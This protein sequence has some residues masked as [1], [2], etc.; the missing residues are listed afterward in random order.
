MIPHLHVYVQHQQQCFAILQLAAPHYLYPVWWVVEE[1]EAQMMMKMKM[2][3]LQ[4]LQRLLRL[5]LHLQAQE[6]SIMTTR[7]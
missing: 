2:M 4:H 5:Q 1:E 7:H 6:E 3:K